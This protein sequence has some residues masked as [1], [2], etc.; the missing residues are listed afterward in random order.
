MNPI[1]RLRKM[2]SMVFQKTNQAAWSLWR[3][4]VPWYRHVTDVLNSSSV[5]V[6][7]M[8]CARNFPEAPPALWDLQT[9]Q[10]THVRDHPMLRLLQRPNP[11]MGGVLFWMATITDWKADGNAYWYKAREPVTGI[12]QE[13]WWIPSWLITPVGDENNY[14]TRY[15][16]SPNSEAIPINREDIVHFR[17]G[18]DPDNTLKGLSPL[19]SVLREVYTDDEAAK[20]VATILSNMGVPGVIISPD[21]AVDPDD[22]DIEAAKADFDERFTGNQRGGVMVMKGATRVNQFGFS[23]EQLRLTEIRRVPE[24]R[25]SAAI[26][27]PAIV[28]GFGAGLDRSTF[29]NMGEALEYAYSNGL[30][31]DQ[32]IMA[33]VVKWDLLSE[34]EEDPFMWKVGF[35]LSEVRALQEDANRVSQRMNAEV[36][37]GVRMVSEH[38]REVKLPV[39]PARD[40]IFLRPANYTQVS[41][42]TGEITTLKSATIEQTAPGGTPPPAP[43]GTNGMVD[44]Q[45]VAAEVLAAIG[46]AE[47]ARGE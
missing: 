19:K 8:W 44:S 46:R 24:E 7:L 20:F 37:A 22:S 16:Y 1:R 28:V 29:T 32:R 21:P 9:D 3:G 26:G 23:P 10:P 12:V 38:R 4:S 13:L 36:L 18:I 39:D 31:P 17:F 14:I 42:D 34:Y 33:D 30:I 41:G 25:V 27:V 6:T 2:V 5:A 15:D 47:Q 35:D 43:N 45:E 11:Y 40:D